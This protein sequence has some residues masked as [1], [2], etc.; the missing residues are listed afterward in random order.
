MTSQLIGS[1]VLTLLGL[2]FLGAAV[3]HERRMQANR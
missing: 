1:S 2:G 3:V